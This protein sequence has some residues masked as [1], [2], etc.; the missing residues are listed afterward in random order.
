MHTSSAAP[1]HHEPSGAGL[2]RRRW[3]LVLLC[4]AQFMLI[5]DLTVVNVALPSIAAGLSLGRGAQTWVVTAYSLCF[6]GLLLLGGRLADTLGRRR[7]FLIGLALFTAASLLSGLAWDAGTLIGARAAQ[8]VGAALLSPAA[9]AIVTT[10]FHGPE[11]TRALGVW[12][13]IGGTGAAAGVLL[14]GLLTSGPGWEW[15]FYVNVPAGLAVLA[16]LPRVVPA[17]APA[18]RPLDLAGAATVTLAAAALIYGLVKAGERGWGSGQA[19]VPLAGAAVLAAAFL[20]VERSVPTPLVPPGLLRRRTIAAGNLL[21][22]AASGLLLSGFFLISQYLQNL[23]D[24]SAVKTGLVFLPVALATIAGA[25]AASTLTGRA[26]PRPVAGAGFALAAAGAFLLSRLPADGS[27]LTGVLPG[28]VLLAAGLGAAFVCAT[29]T[30]M[31]GVSHD[32]AGLASGVV[33]TG[34]EI[35]GALGIALATALAGASVGGQAVDGFHTAFAAFTAV[36]AATAVLAL[37]L[38]P[39]GRPDPG[40]GPVFAH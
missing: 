32:E 10:S 28:F 38:V 31:N 15:V 7:A 11:R 3:A 37:L 22:L 26:G 30:A 18:R 36:G 13:A 4:L 8:G 34:H 29:A 27:A 39:A 21:M 20:L 5:V 6:G 19:L 35:G 23:L 14:G 33:S 12:A 17:A 1:P 9:L 2:P 24:Y 16:A 25:H 40:D